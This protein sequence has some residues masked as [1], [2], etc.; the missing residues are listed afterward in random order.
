MRTP[1]DDEEFRKALAGVEGVVEGQG[2]ERLGEH[3]AL[4]AHALGGHRR[5]APD[6]HDLPRPL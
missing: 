3:G 5:R 6:M 1:P 2:A 4:V